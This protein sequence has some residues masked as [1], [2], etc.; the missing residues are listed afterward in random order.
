MPTWWR[1]WTGVWGRSCRLSRTRESPTILFPY[2]PV[3][4]APGFR[5]VRGDCAE[6]NRKPTKAAC[7]A[8]FRVNA[9]TP[10]GR[11]GSLGLWLVDGHVANIRRPCRRSLARAPARW[12]RYLA[13]DVG[14]SGRH[15]ETGIALFR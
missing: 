11:N 4:T 2:S 15:R 5:E 12:H 3:I 14:R 10:S 6:E 7:G 1:K 9:G 8:F 13:D